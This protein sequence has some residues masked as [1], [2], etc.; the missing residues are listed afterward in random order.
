[1]PMDSLNVYDVRNTAGWVM[2]RQEERNNLFFKRHAD[3]RVKLEES[4]RGCAPPCPSGESGGNI[5]E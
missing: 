4:L 5:G 3:R 2:I 1:M